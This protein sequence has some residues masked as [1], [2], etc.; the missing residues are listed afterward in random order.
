MLTVTSAECHHIYAPHVECRYA[1]CRGASLVVF[2]YLF[3]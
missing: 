3:K 1:K 2:N